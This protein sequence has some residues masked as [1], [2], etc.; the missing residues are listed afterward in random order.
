ML[1]L[2]P[3]ADV[4]DELLDFAVELAGVRANA[5]DQLGESL[6]RDSFLPGAD[7]FA[8]PGLRL[9]RPVAIV[10]RPAGQGFHGAELVERFV[11]HL[12]LVHLAGA[13][14]QADVLPGEVLQFLRQ[15]H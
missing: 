11:E 2:L 6:V 15:A 10:H 13:D 1:D 7:G 3:V 14:E 9:V 12:A 5:A 8:G 4:K